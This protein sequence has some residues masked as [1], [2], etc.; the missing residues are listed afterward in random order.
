MRELETQMVVFLPYEEEDELV[1]G[2]KL[3][4][5]GE[6]AR[7]AEERHLK[8][9]S[10]PDIWNGVIPLWQGVVVPH[11]PEEAASQP[12]Q[13]EDKEAPIPYSKRHLVH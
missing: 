12:C 6:I 10:K 8:D 11:F 4:G 9:F 2:K 7:I 5:K 1:H 13:R 3:E